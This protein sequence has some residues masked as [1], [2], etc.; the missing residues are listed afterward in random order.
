MHTVSRKSE[1]LINLT[2]ALLATKRYLTKSEIFRSVAGYD[3]EI[4]AR[5][6]MFERDKDDLRAIGIE[7]EL[8]SFDPL[9]EDEAGY[10]IKREKYQVQIDQLTPDELVLLD[11]AAT[12]W[13]DASMATESHS[14]IR[15]LKSLGIAIDEDLLSSTYIPKIYAPEQLPDLIEAISQ[16]QKISFEYLDIEGVSQLRSVAP[17]RLTCERGLWYLLTLDLDKAEFRTFRVDRF[18]SSVA[19]I[20]KAGSYEIDQELL[21]NSAHSARVSFPTAVIAL[22]RGRG[23]HLRTLAPVTEID[24]EWER[25]EI[26][27]L[28]SASIIEQVLWLGTDARVLQPQELVD[29]LIE[30]LK[31]TVARNG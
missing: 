30:S 22:R 18:N 20:S 23:H 8:G 2:I 25:I 19:T 3:G 4:D 14:A 27:S 6:R 24:D 1:R 16:L 11:Y 5:D 7:I 10:R 9:F 31:A 29:S 26:D 21:S 13:R 17:Y 15:K 28:D 12:S